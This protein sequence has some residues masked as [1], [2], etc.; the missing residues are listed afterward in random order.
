MSWSYSGNPAFSTR[1]KVRFLIGDTDTTDQQLSNEEI[2]AALVDA[3]SNPY[4]AAIIC[5]EA[6]ISHYARLCNKSVGDLSIS[7]GNIANNYRKLLGDLRRRS[8]LQLC[9]PYAGGISISDKQTDEEDSDRVQPSFY[10]EMHDTNGTQTE[11]A[12][13]N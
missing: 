4:V 3:S 12:E 9:T 8:T 10:K 5:T 6:L 13:E 7:Y 2:D 11:L 1:D